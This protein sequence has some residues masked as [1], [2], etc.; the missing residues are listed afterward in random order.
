MIMQKMF[1][2]TLEPIASHPDDMVDCEDTGAY[3]RRAEC[4]KSVDG[5]FWEAREERYDHERDLVETYFKDFIEWSDEHHAS[6]DC[7]GEYAYLVW[8][9][10]EQITGNVREA[11]GNLLGDEWEDSDVSNDDL[12]DDIVEALSEHVEFD[13]TTG[14]HGWSKHD[15]NFD[16]FDIGEV[17]EQ[18]S[19]NEHDLLRDLNVRGDLE[20]ILVDLGSDFYFQ[21]FSRAI[22]DED[23]KFTSK[24]EYEPIISRGEYPCIM[25]TNDT[26]LWYHYGCSDDTL[27]EVYHQCKE[28]ADNAV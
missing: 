11:L 27:E 2:G 8:E 1:D 3:K 5:K 15:V 14:Y 28:E 24:Y 22:R 17:E 13:T 19:I 23:G 10:R 12:V 26:S 21:Q 16:S 4:V 9:N 25:L 7:V 20:E 18:V 6:D